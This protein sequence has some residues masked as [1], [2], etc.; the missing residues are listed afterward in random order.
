MKGTIQTKEVSR[1]AELAGC[2]S[3]IATQLE[4]IKRLVL[5]REGVDRIEMENQF[6]NRLFTRYK[7]IR[8]EMN[9]TRRVD[10]NRYDGRAAGALDREV[11]AREHRT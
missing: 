5:D 11:Q 3:L 1:D 2:E 7:T 6:L 8:R 4:L 9:R 10:M